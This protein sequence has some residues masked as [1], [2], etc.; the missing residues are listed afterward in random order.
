M[1]NVNLKLEQQIRNINKHEE[2]NLDN[3]ILRKEEKEAM[4]MKKYL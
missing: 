1:Y 4:A 3:K 2:I